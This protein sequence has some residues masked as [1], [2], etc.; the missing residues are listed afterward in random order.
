MKLGYLTNLMN[1]AVG[2]ILYGFHAECHVIS[3]P[4]DL[5][6]LGCLSYLYAFGVMFSHS[7]L[8]YLSLCV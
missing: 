5:S 4:S 6:L 1:Y 7:R 2:R 3:L 8:I